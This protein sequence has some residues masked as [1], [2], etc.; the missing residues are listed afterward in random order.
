MVYQKS[1]QHNNAKPVVFKLQ[2]TDNIY[3]NQP[4]INYKSDN[5]GNKD[6]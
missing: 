1:I 3:S 2:D 5:K 4:K 6:S